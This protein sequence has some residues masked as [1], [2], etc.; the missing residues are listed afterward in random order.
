MRISALRVGLNEITKRKSTKIMKLLK[1]S[2]V[3]AVAALVGFGTS[4]RATGFTGIGNGTYVFTAAAGQLTFANGSTVTFSGN[5]LIAWDLLD[6][7]APANVDF[8]LVYNIPGDA[9]N[10]VINAD[11]AGVYANNEWAYNIDSTVSTSVAAYFEIANNAIYDGV[12]DP[13]GSWSV[14]TS[15]ARV[16]DASGT[17]QLMAG[18]LTALGACGSF[19]RRRS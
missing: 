8:P 6:P 17:F 13:T 15:Q 18:A 2:V 9:N 16:P 10:S 4:A 11:S 5:E 3:A 19:L 7:S 1:L 14:A 12:G